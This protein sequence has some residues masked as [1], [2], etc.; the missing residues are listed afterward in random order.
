GLSALGAVDPDLVSGDAV[1]RAMSDIMTRQRE[2]AQALLR[3][4]EGIIRRL[5]ARVLECETLSGEEIR[6]ILEGERRPPGGTT[7]KV[8]LL[9]PPSGREGITSRGQNSPAGVKKP[10]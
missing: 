8:R 10:A 4:R 9:R 7:R 6:S 2:R 1:Q 3:P 5:A